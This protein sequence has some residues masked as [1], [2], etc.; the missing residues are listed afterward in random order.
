MAA[1]SVTLAP[2]LTAMVDPAARAHRTWGAYHR[3]RPF[4]RT[5]KRQNESAPTAR[6]TDSALVVEITAS[7]APDLP[8]LPEDGP[9]GDNHEQRDDQIEH[10]RDLGPQQPDADRDG[11]GRQAGVELGAD[12]PHVIFGVVPPDQMFGH[13]V[14]P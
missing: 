5:P 3:G 13:R 9:E 14:V 2:C 11:I 8:E 10:H 6:A 1:S 12:G 4:I 7:A